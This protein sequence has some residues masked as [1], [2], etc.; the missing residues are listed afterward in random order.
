MIIAL[1]IDD[2]ISANPKFF[3]FLSHAAMNAGYTVIIITYRENREIAMQDLEEW[4]IAWD[5][6]FTATM[7]DLDTHGFNKWKSHICRE[8]G[9][10][11]FFEDMIEV[12]DHVDESVT[13]F[14][15]G[16]LTA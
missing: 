7:E 15:V 9:V 8:E 16:A 10:N 12:L 1:D 14:L 3:S 2:T 11:V 4:G 5:K 13:K 6:L